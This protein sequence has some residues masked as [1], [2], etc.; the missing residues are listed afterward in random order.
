VAGFDRPAKF[1]SNYSFP[2][3]HWAQPALPRL[4]MD[5]RGGVEDGYW[6]RQQTTGS[7]ACFY[8]GTAPLILAF[9][10]LAAGHDRA[11]GPWKLVIPA[12]WLLATLPRLWP[13]GYDAVLQ[14]PG[15]GYFRCPARYTLLTS[16]GL[17]LLAGRGLDRAIGPRR[18][19]VGLALAV[20]FGAGSAAWAWHWAR[21]SGLLDR[22]GE[23]SL[24]MRFGAAAPAWGVGLAAILAWRS[25]R[26]GAWAP[27]AVAA[28]ELGILFHLGPTPWGWS[29]DV[30]AESP[31]LRAL[32]DEPG[33][34]LIAGRLEDIPV[35][36]GLAPAFPYLGIVPPPPNYLL[37]AAK[38]P[39][40]VDDP[41]TR[42]WL[43]RFG[44][45]HG[46]WEG[47]VK[48]SGAE[49]IYEGPDPALDRLVPRL[50]D[51]PPHATWRV[52]RHAEADPPAHVALRVREASDWTELYPN[53]S[54]RD[55][56]SEVWYLAADRPA[57]GP[58][59]RARSAKLVAWDGRRAVVEHDGD[60]DLVVRRTYY[61]GWEA[62]IDGAPA[63]PVTK[64]DGGLQAVRLEGS[65][66]S[67]VEFRY[68][69]TD[70]VPAA[71]TSA[72]A[73][74]AALLALI[75]AAMRRRPSRGAP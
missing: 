5:L 26:V 21:E 33:V 67:R 2:P 70:L 72:L 60:C 30:K 51:A 36:A 37:E 22:L 18:F 43:R 74:S 29:V 39:E 24:P 62:S 45:T 25:G 53:L 50:H 35:R 27:V 28:V 56:P 48:P 49:V 12:T 42:R 52:L 17:C 16:L 58:G 61:P 40:K 47:H 13:D 31:A 14:L 10:G 8:V 11:L 73:T 69:P 64:A 38:A 71:M 1:L 63:R 19:G 46:V 75:G 65:G 7:E 23:S 4:F 41:T 6:R 55:D 57:D 34:G 9:V 54:R 59:P 44:V 15:L 66:N 32:A 3:A 68:R 20:L